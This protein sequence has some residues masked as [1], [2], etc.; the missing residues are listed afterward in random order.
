[1]PEI[2]KLAGMKNLLKLGVLLVLSGMLGSCG[3]P[4]AAVRTAQSTV[5]SAIATAQN[6]LGQ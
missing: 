5:R 2:E 1:V 4:M 3:I 6:P